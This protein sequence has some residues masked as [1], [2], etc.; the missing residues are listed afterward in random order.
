MLHCGLHT[1]SWF[2]TG[3]D[4]YRLCKV[5]SVSVCV[6]GSF[7]VDDGLKVWFV[8]CISCFHHNNTHGTPHRTTE[9]HL[10]LLHFKTELLLEITHATHSFQGKLMYTQT[11]IVRSSLKSRH[12]LSFHNKL[13]NTHILHG[14]RCFWNSKG[15]VPAFMWTILFS[16]WSHRRWRSVSSV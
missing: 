2:Y 15:A 6:C 13:E 14:T 12:T 7:S 16:H 5:T 1:V 3:V 8:T 10:E 4:Y 11:H 9:K